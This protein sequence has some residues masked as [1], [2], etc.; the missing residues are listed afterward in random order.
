MIV[1]ILQIFYN[2]GNILQPISL[3]VIDRIIIIKLSLVWALDPLLCTSVVC[4]TIA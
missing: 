3:A 4:I 1:K 2:T